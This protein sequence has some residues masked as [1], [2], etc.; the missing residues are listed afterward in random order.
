MSRAF[1][2]GDSLGR[3][4]SVDLEAGSRRHRAFGVHGSPAQAVSHAM[5]EIARRTPDLCV[6]GVNY[7]ENLG[8]SVF[9]S[10]TIGAALEAYTYGIPGLAVSLESA[11]ELHCAKHYQTM[12]WQLATKVT[13]LLAAQ[14]LEEG[15]PGDIA[16]L[17]VNVPG[18][19]TP[20]TEIRVTTQS[21]QDYLVLERPGTR[22]FASPLRLET[23]V[24]I[25]HSTLEADSDIRAFALDRVV[26]VTPL[27]WT[28]TARERWGLRS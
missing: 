22:D 2:I 8:M 13:R 23:I 18:C 7:G 28:L 5:L 24:R 3:I 27:T 15:L 14:I 9:H 4:E 11:V 26:S 10:G 20:D 19:A 1:P 21:A 17:N 16:L 12:D 6:S 25:D